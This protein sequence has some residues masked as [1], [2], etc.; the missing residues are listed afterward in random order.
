MLPHE[1]EQEILTT[2]SENIRLYKIILFGS[3]AH[4]HPDRDSDI[5][6]LVV[7]DDDHLPGNY[8]EHMTQYLKV[9]SL[10]KKLKKRIAIDLIVHTR[11]MHEAFIRSGSM[12]SREILK[13]GDVLYEKN[14]G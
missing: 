12:F 3:F 14:S 5:D 11:P 13:R 1:I 6:L 4:G 8:T 9:S 10:L 2:L 7:T